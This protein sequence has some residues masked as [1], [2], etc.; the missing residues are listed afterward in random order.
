MVPTLII[1]GRYSDSRGVLQYNNT[2]D[3]SAVK[4]LYVIQN[5]D[6]SFIRGWQGHRIEQRWFSALSGSFEIHLIKIDNW[7]SPSKSLQTA[8]F[9]LNSENL[10]VLYVPAGYIT[11][12]QSKVNDA[13]LLVMSDHLLGKS[14]DEY[15][16]PLNYFDNKKSSKKN[17]KKN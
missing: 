6:P 7:K 1:G 11:R 5:T 9:N 17:D 2:F 13:K 3:A 4:R 14:N 8:I 16:F 12:I 15:R 10:D